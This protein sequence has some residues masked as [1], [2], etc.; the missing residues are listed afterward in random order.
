MTEFL[1]GVVIGLAASGH[2]AA[3]CGPLVLAVG[4]T[5]R[6]P[7]RAAQVGHAALYHAGRIAIYLVLAAIAGMLGMALTPTAAGRAAAVAAAIVLLDRAL[8]FRHGRM[9][10]PVATRYRAIVGRIGG[11]TAGWMQR[12]G[13]AGPLAGGAVHG[14][15]PCGLL[16]A[17]LTAAAATA[18]V[19]GA[20]ALMAG[21][22]AGTTPGLAA[23]AL[24]SSAVPVRV[25]TALGRLTPAAL[26]LTAALLLLRAFAPPAQHP[27][28][29][30][31]AALHLAHRK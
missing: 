9:P 13:I 2:C 18:S 29:T 24:A 19:G 20:I 31:P 8:G 17:A 11:F 26:A 21:F 3:M 25:R 28:D 10:E 16:Y 7:T 23:L 5:L 14:L 1:S 27:G 30:H 15:M 12:H 22:G 6:R 4:R